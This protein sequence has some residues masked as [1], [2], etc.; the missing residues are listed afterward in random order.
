MI[1]YAPDLEPLYMYDGTAI[2]MQSHAQLE[3]EYTNTVYSTKAHEFQTTK[4]SVT[5]N[6]ATCSKRTS[7]RIAVAR[8][9]AQVES[10]QVQYVT[11]IV[12]QPSVSDSGRRALAA[13]RHGSFQPAATAY[14]AGTLNTNG[15]AHCVA[16]APVVLP[17]L[18]PPHPPVA[19][20][21]LPPTA[22]HRS[23]LHGRLRS[24]KAAAHLR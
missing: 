18:P 19:S 3:L 15:P 20:P 24:A 4:S 11:F 9:G 14:E 8:A 2:D 22:L 1:Y 17:P 6:G 23:A 7:P 21:S 12:F 5:T 13:P 10:M 16:P